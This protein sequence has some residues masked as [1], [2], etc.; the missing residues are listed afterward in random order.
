MFELDNL[1]YV[2]PVAG[3]LALLFAYIKAGWVKKQDAGTDSMKE[4]AG[5]I[6]DG[7]MAFLAAEYKVLAIFV[8]IVAALLAAANMGGE[9]VAS[10]GHRSP[11]IALSFVVGAVCSGLGRVTWCHHVPTMVVHSLDFVEFVLLA[12]CVCYTLHP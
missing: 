1:I 5:W 3:L 4:I 12:S 10:G 2:A 11:L 8:V 9:A 6:Q 7:A